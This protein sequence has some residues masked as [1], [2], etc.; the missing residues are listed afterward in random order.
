MLDIH[1][2]GTSDDR[3]PVSRKSPICMLHEA[4][5]QRKL[6]PRTPLAQTAALGPAHGGGLISVAT[7]DKRIATRVATG[8]IDDCT[9]ARIAL[10]AAKS[11]RRFDQPA[12]PPSLPLQSITSPGFETV[13]NRLL[14]MSPWMEGARRRDSDQSATPSVLLHRFACSDRVAIRLALDDGRPLAYSGISSY[15]DAKL[16][17]RWACVGVAVSHPGP[18]FHLD[19]LGA[20]S[21]GLA[22]VNLSACSFDSTPRLPDWDVM[23]VAFSVLAESVWVAFWMV[24]D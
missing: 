14:R 13:W 8:A 12:H 15:R 4:P 23:M 19:R 21:Q 7:F 18:R 9:A 17:G 6:W 16:I 3:P 1:A 10:W 24:L 22:F 2:F 20:P 5:G 11:G